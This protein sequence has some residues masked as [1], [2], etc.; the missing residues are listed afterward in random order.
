M[1][2]TFRIEPDEDKKKTFLSA[3]AQRFGDF[4]GKLVSGWITC[5]RKVTGRKG[6]K[7]KIEE[8]ESGVEENGETEKE[9]EEEGPP[10]K[11][12]RMPWQIWDHI[13]KPDWEAFVAKKTTPSAVVSN[14]I[15]C[16]AYLNA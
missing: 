10:Y 11:P 3:V 14:Y 9:G 13:T 16:A 5:T 6:K 12:D 8:K 2:N 1:Q 7:R 15:R 4:K